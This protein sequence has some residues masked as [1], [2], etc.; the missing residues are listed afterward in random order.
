VR[1][2]LLLEAIGKAE[3]LVVTDDDVEA[4]FAEL[5]ADNGVP[6]TTVKKQYAQD[7]ARANL[8]SRLLDDKVMSFLRSHATYV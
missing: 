1:G 7:E 8:R 3:A 4:K 5:A 2:Q 6:V